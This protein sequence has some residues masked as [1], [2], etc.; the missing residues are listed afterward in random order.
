[1]A[2]VAYVASGDTELAEDAVQAAWSIVWRKLARAAQPCAG[3]IHR[4]AGSARS[5]GGW[6]HATP[7]RPFASDAAGLV[8]WTLLL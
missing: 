8:P 5:A 3:A 6:R 1:M 7:E 4:A 2:R